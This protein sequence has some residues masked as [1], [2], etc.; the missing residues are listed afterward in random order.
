M[1]S[2][3]YGFVCLW[4]GMLS[5]GLAAEVPSEVWAFLDTHCMECHDA[6]A[7][8]GM[9]RLDEL[10][11]DVSEKTTFQNWQ[12]VMERVAT[13]EMPPAKRERP[14]PQEL[15]T[16]VSRVR[17]PL[18]VED[19]AR[20]ATHG[21]AV[22]RRLNRHEYENSLRDLLGAPWLAVKDALPEDGEAYGFNKSGEALSIS[23]VQM[24]RYLAVAENALRQSILQQPHSPEAA[25]VKRYFARE[26]EAFSRRSFY[27]EF[28][29]SPERATFP[30]LGNEADLAY[31]EA[32]RDEVLKSENETTR[33]TGAMG[34]VA[35]T[36]EPLEIKFDAFEAPISGRYRLRLKAYSFW[37]APESEEKWT[38]PSRTHLSKGRTV[39]P[40]TLY[41][42]RP[43]RLLRRLGQMEFPAEPAERELEVFLEQGETIRPDAV[44]LFRSRPPGPWRNPL[45]TREGQPGV[46][47]AWLE[48]EGPITEEW[49]NRAQKRLFDDLPVHR[50]GLEFRVESQHP[51]ADAK[52]LMD[53][54]LA[55]AVRRPLAAEERA[56]FLKLT[57]CLIDQGHDLA[58]ALIS[59]Y[60][61]VLCSPAFLV[62]EEKSGALDAH[63]VASRLSYFL[64]NSMPDEELR[65]L[66]DHDRLRQPD[67]LRDQV[68]RLLKHPHA[69]RF[70]DTFLNYW[71]DLRKLH[72]TSPDE[73]LYPDYYLDDDLVD[74]AE[75]ETR[76]FFKTLV[77]E[78]QPVKSL[79]APGFAMLNERLAKHYGIDGVTGV[80]IR[81]VVLPKDSTRGGLLGQASVLKVTANGTTTSPVLRGVWIMERILGEPVPPPPTAVPAIEPDTR[82]T[83]SIREQLDQHRSQEVCNSCHA[84][85]DPVGFALESFDVFGGWRHHYR[86]SDEKV[87]AVKFGKN[88]QPLLVRD[89]PLIEPFGTMHWGESFA[90][91]GELIPMLARRD[92]QL[93]RNILQHFIVYST[94]APV[95]ISDEAELNRLLDAT[96]GRGFGLRDLLHALVQSPLFLSK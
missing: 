35:S 67:V 16:F 11:T 51:V 56:S 48:V 81:P 14:D 64:W 65:A 8:T 2:V 12:R 44:R 20:V 66:A 34:V 46:A 74:A 53:R 33:L 62:L 93:A 42:E 76:A 69:D 39:E 43:P 52:R 38:R 25:P 55:Q 19:R 68:E 84:K 92:R 1:K 49:P 18:L 75:A 54:F 5:M 23:H 77:R 6:G 47:F 36:Y 50:D 26:Q 88:G 3:V 57:Q 21:R 79:I 94:G 29:R 17:Q 28:N 27:N 91:L 31:L 83:T 9:L 70:F 90:H 95:T 96:E 13:G 63:A 86:A 15:S 73:R 41:S 7:K 80:Q 85:M 87:E 58:T 10:A 32:S 37:A 78:N 59:G 22:L 89:G 71:L 30:M 45:A 61:A 72:D 24:S 60:A 4:S 82:G 40:V